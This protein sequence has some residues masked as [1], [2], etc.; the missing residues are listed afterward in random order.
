MSSTKRNT[1]GRSAWPTL[2]NV[3]LLGNYL[4]RRCGIATFTSDLADAL[5][6]AA[7]NVGV[8]TVAMNDRP[9]GY[10]YP[11]R[12]WFEV[13][14][15]RLGEYK[16]AA[17]FLNMSG[18]DVVS[19]QHEF[20]IFGG[21]AGAHLYDLLPRLRMPVVATLHTVLK[22]PEP[23]YRDGMAELAKHCDRFVVMAER[24]YDFLTDIYKI[25]KSR[26]RLIHHGIPDVPFVD[27]AFYKDQFGVEGKKVIFTF[28]LLG[29]SK[30]LEN[31]IEALPAVIAK[32]PDAV[33]MVLGATHPGVLAHSGE[34]Y[35]LGLQRRAKELGVDKHIVW[36]NKFVELEEL[37]E[38]LGSA[39]VYVTPYENEAQIT[40][41]TLAYALGTGKATVSTPYWY[42][43]EM[44]ADGRGKLV[45]FKD[46]KAM[47]DAI[48]DLFE[49]EVSR[50][51]MR[52]KAYQFT[53]EMRWSNIAEQYLDLFAE[54]REERNR[55]PKPLSSNS[56]KRKFTPELQEIKLDHLSMLTDDCGIL[57]HAKQTVPDRASGYTTTNNARALV[58]VLVAQDHMKSP[59]AEAKLLD[60]SAGRYL[61]F[62]EHAFD[63]NAGRFRNRMDFD[64][65]WQHRE[66]SEDAHGQAIRALGE[67]VARSHLRGHTNLAANLFQRALPACESFEHVHGWA[68]SLIGIH[69]Y[70]RKFSGDS[71]ARRLRE[72]LAHKLFAA[73]KNNASHDWPW[74]TDQI[75]YTASRLPH[76][77]LLSGRWMFNNAMIQQALR[78]LEWLQKIQ[79][80]GADGQFAPV[81]SL[82]WYPRGG[83]KAR[84]NQMPAE[85]SGTIDANLEAFRVTADRKWLDRAYKCLNW[86]MGDNDLRQP[87]YDNTTGGCCDALLPQGVDENQGA[88]ATVSWLLSLLSLYEH[89]LDRDSREPK[90]SPAV[91]DVAS[92]TQGSNPAT[93]TKSTP[94]TPHPSP[95]AITKGLTPKRPGTKNI[96]ETPA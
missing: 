78:S 4:P 43:Q 91:G 75:T 73:F 87:L 88:Q 68:Y 72:H 3:S 9:E 34:E 95:P 94:A 32:H 92:D 8:H 18:V 90:S 85:A 67:T 77:L 23:K 7:P 10:R 55:K 39:D 6:A 69:A 65:T 19:L 93:P 14:E 59:A 17:D 40:S 71:S 51:A 61:A 83:Q 63:Q 66:F 35:R 2:N 44:L 80:S 27:P 84:F 5:A 86:F 82:G 60:L 36:F 12:V 81:G 50:H 52:K 74:P 31:M 38:F 76:A 47:S 37:V 21:D 28:G 64:R 22:D 57:S 46:T 58:A 54:V 15:N 20:G 56:A 70:L 62:L 29:P 79:Y 25:D 30:G 45:P 48:I 96:H 49:N 1:V 89:N 16:L 42:A 13:N 53:R 24:A 11:S 33:Y 26:I 41:G